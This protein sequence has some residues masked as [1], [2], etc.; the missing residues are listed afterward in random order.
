MPVL[1]CT[2]SR[3]V[4]V[5]IRLTS[6]ACADKLKYMSRL[7]FAAL[8]SLALVSSQRAAAQRVAGRDLLDFPLGLLA[9]A[10]ALSSQL[11]GGFWS[12]ATAMLAPASRAAFGFAGL[13]T[14]QELGVQL[15]MLAA[16]YKLRPNV[17]GSF[18]IV[19]ASVADV[20]RTDTDPTSLGGEISY[21]TTVASIGAATTFRKVTVGAAAR[22]RWGSADAD[23][24]GAFAFDVGA[25]ADSVFR[26]PLRIA[27]STFLFNPSSSS[28]DA[29]YF[30]AA[31]LPVIQRD[32]TVMVRAGY[33]IGHAERRGTESLV[34]ATGT[35]RRVEL[36]SGLA[37]VNEF[38]NVTERWR[39]GLGV[40]R[41]GYL[42]AIGR[43]A[44]GAGIGA[45][46]QFLLTRTIK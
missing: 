17:T 38:G 28:N 3:G 21:G 23:R 34:F 30:A 40:R 37:I 44:G 39:L 36:N 6:S 2:P 12:P 10:P 18:S 15:D 5:V 7:M 43:E 46:Y 26:T 8:A 9:E 22:Y 35:Y 16:A 32:S 45:S 14:P 4:A 42:V 20:L 24:S 29:A 11:N 25:I 27:A 31:D 41:A 19:D 33:S 1:E 13:T